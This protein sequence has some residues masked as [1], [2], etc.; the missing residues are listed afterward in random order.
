VFLLVSPF[1]GSLSA[2][3]GSRNL[4]S[5]GLAIIGSGLLLLGSTAS[6][7]SIA[8]AEIG[9]ALT[10]LGMGCATGP[11]MGIA[12]GAV[13]PARA[14]TASSL[15]NV[16]R[17]AG[18]TLGVAVLGAVFTIADGGPQGLRLAMVL[19]GTVQIACA[20]LAWTIARR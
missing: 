8:P 11:L 10:G 19:A 13:A 7:A 2:R 1:S 20:A 12:V 14:G 6:R 18:A 17:M 3:F 9:L 4:T 15:I 16:V 5:A